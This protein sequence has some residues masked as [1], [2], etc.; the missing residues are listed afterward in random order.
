MSQ[1]SLNQLSPTAA[2]RDAAPR[3]TSPIDGIT[4]TLLRKFMRDKETRI[5]VGRKSKAVDL[6]A[7][8]P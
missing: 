7:M 8:L 2:K 3:Y 4:D 5:L 6:D 1:I